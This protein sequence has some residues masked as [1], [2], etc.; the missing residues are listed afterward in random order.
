MLLAFQTSNTRKINYAI[1]QNSPY[2]NGIPFI[3]IYKL[4]LVYKKI[5]RISYIPSVVVTNAINQP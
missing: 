4:G 1:I 5:T 3:P 2:P